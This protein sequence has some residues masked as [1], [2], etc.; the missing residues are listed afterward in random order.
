MTDH[1]YNWIIDNTT[2]DKAHQLELIDKRGLSEKEIAEQKYRSS[3]PELLKIEAKIKEVFPIEVLIRSGVFTRTLAGSAG[4][5][6]M[7]LESRILI[8]Y[9][10]AD[11]KAYHLRPHKLGFSDVPAQIFQE[12]NLARFAV[13]GKEIEAIL[14]EGEFKAHAGI[15]Y[16]IPTIGI[17]GISSFSEMHFPELVAICQKYNV[18]K[19]IILFDNEVKDDPKFPAKYKDNPNDRHDTPFY[20]AYMASKLEKQGIDALVGWLPDAWRVDGKIDLD[21]AAAQGRTAGEIKR[22]M[23]D[24]VKH[25][26]FT[27][28]LPKEAAEVVKRKMTQKFHRSR[29][30]KEFGQYIA[31]RQKGKSTVTEPIS[32]FIMKILAT[33]ETT[34]GIMREIV[35][36]G[37]NGKHSSSFTASADDIANIRNFTTFCFAK[38]NFVWRGLQEDLMTIW[39]DEFLMMDEGRHIIEPDHI[40]WIE[41]EKM[42]VFGNVAIDREGKELRPD[43]GHTFWVEKKGIKAVSLAVGVSDKSI[44]A[45]GVP[46]LS[47]VEFSIETVIQKLAD[48]IGENEAKQCLGWVT[49][50]LFLEDVFERYGSFPFLF[51]TGKRGSGKSTVAEWLMNFFGLENAGKMASETTVVALQRY[52]SYYSSLPVFVDEYRNTDQVKYKTGMLRNAYNRQSA[53]KG[54]REGWGVREAKIR[55]TV[56]ISGEETPEDNALMTRCIPIMLYATNRAPSSAENFNWLRANRMKFSWHTLNILKNKKQLMEKFFSV[57]EKAR[58]YFVAEGRDERTAINYSTIAAG[59]SVAIGVEDEDFAK[60]ISAETA[61]VQSEFDEEQSTEVFWE[62]LSAMRTKGV[63][64]GKYW[65]RGTWN[66]VPAYFLY[67][68]GAYNEFSQEFRKTRGSVPFKKSAVRAYLKEEPGFLEMRCHHAVKGHV[69]SC[70]AFEIAKAPVM[71]RNLIDSPEESSTN[72]II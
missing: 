16:G 56:L 19:M 46:C 70:I 34:A 50:V 24:A 31:K 33:H 8:P 67:F 40:G 12:K 64:D 66:G 6:P 13:P 26:D 7:L 72:G 9:L 41:S 36:V 61:R 1:P 60:W 23:F 45:D 47:T 17:P 58:K 38:G 3:G 52:M 32:N 44:I 62:Y 11:D 4:M 35:F 2:L 71:L 65:D 54:T 10:G 55:G 5:N 68:E 25:Q 42:W 27:K 39:E 21:G 57:F 48:A 22:I 20:A 37:E 14:T 30:T 18:K 43:K 28:L 69:K 29:I 53:G 51:I 15:Q 63:I 59:Y 49:A